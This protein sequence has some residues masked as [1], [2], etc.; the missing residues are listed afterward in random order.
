MF[1]AKEKHKLLDHWSRMDHYNLEYVCH[2][3]INYRFGSLTLVCQF[4]NIN[5]EIE[6]ST[7]KAVQSI[8][9]KPWQSTHL[10]STP[11]FTVLEVNFN[12]QVVQ[13]WKYLSLIKA[14]VLSEFKYQFCLGFVQIW[15]SI[16]ARL[17]AKHY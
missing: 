14:K 7:W 13:F 8:P 15:I 2:S 6:M 3:S 10:F 9:A 11:P 16:E 17:M 5:R 1:P 4:I 12:C